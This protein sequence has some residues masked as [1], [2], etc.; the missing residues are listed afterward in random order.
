MAVAVTA[1]VQRVVD[2]A[3]D[4]ARLPGGDPDAPAEVANEVFQAMRKNAPAVP[5]G[6]VV[7]NGFA[8]ATVAVL[9]RDGHLVCD[10][11]RQRGKVAR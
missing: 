7:E 3:Y 9:V 4:E 10:D 6:L 11:K 1:L 8:E 5:G 2:R